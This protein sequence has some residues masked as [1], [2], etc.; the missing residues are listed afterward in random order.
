MWG[1]PWRRCFRK[2]NQIVNVL[3]TSR[4]EYRNKYNHE[5]IAFAAGGVAWLFHYLSRSK[6][7]SRFTPSEYDANFKNLN[8]QNGGGD[9]AEFRKRFL[10]FRKSNNWQ[11]FTTTPVLDK[12]LSSK[13]ELQGSK[14]KVPVVRA[15]RLFARFHSGVQVK[16]SCN[17]E[18]N[19]LHQNCNNSDG[20][21]VVVIQHGMRSSG[22]PFFPLAEEIH[23]H[24]SNVE[25][26]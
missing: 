3:A 4:R 21:Y 6:Q 14:E 13:K 16:S 23:K 12:V 17:P 2:R 1:S 18:S 22:A 19:R 8:D 5:K 25:E 10:R 26:N 7:E 9:E 24:V 11:A 15:E 20:V